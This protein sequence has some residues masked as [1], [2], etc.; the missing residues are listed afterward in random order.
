MLR[1]F[2]VWARSVEVRAINLVRVQVGV[3]SMAVPWLGLFLTSLVIFVEGLEITDD[4]DTDI[5]TL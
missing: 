5:C 2:C 4:A 3:V 1:F